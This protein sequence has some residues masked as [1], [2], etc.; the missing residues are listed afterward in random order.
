MSSDQPSS[1]EREENQSPWDPMDT[2]PAGRKW[3][4]AILT[5]FAVILQGPSCLKELRVT[6]KEGNDFFQDWTSGQCPRR[7]AC[8]YTARR[9][10][11]SPCPEGRGEAPTQAPVPWNAHPPTSVLAMLPLGLLDYPLRGNALECIESDRP[12]SEPGYRAQLNFPVPAWSILPIMTLGLLC[13]PIRTQVSQ[14]QW[15]APLLLVLTLAWVAE[16]RG[17]DS[18]AGIWVGRACP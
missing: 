18:W 8:L 10:R 1:L 4:W 7:A 16:R 6:S 3:I 5:T 12:G 15:N 11:V 13:S 2:W 9:V 14:G 17:R